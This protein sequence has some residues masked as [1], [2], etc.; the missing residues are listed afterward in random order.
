MLKSPPYHINEIEKD[1]EYVAKKL[2]ITVSELDGFLSLP[3]SYYTDYKNWDF[4]ISYANKA[5]NFFK[6]YANSNR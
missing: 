3:R 5:R 1:K 6:E 4:L 2:E